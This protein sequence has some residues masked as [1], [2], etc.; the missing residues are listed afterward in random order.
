MDV[1]EPR[2]KGQA[3]VEETVRL[4]ADS[5]IF[6]NDHGLLRK[7]AWVESRDGTHSSTFRDP[8][9]EAGVGIWQM[10]KTTF[11]D[12]RNN[13]L[14]RKKELVQKIISTFGIDLTSVSRE[15][16]YESLIAALYARVLLVRFPEAIPSDDKGQAK[17]WKDHYN[18]KS[19]KGTP[20]KF[21]NDMRNLPRADQG[22]FVCF[23]FIY[24][25]MQCL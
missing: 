15:D 19:G 20:E 16:L 7:I 3:V 13:Y 6:P 1:R 18:T 21:L 5:G 25:L 4:I 23:L 10:D 2:A 14:K 17:Y 11:E 22:A 8:T 9:S 24:D 12:L